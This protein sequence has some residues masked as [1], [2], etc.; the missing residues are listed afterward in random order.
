MS[1]HHQSGAREE[2]WSLWEMGLIVSWMGCKSK[3]VLK[4][5]PI[6][7][8][9]KMGELKIVSHEAEFPRGPEVNVGLDQGQLSHDQ[10]GDL[11]R[12]R[13]LLEKQVEA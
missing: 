3:E 13:N 6:V 9:M 2:R 8:K 11:S 7:Q 4:K 10:K 5:G 12:L 1:S